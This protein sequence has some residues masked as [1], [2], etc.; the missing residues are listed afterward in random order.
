MQIQQQ[1]SKRR[2]AEQAEELRRWARCAAGAIQEQIRRQ[3]QSSRRN[4]AS[5]Q[6][7]AVA[8]TSSRRAAAVNAVSLAQAA[9]AAEGE[10][11]PQRRGSSK[12]DPHEAASIT[13]QVVTWNVRCK[14]DCEAVTQGLGGEP[15]DIVCLQEVGGGFASCLHTVIACDDPG[16]ATRTAIVVHRRRAGHVVNCVGSH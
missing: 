6:A 5:R 3:W 16:G 4:A 7:Q 2:Y 11:E 15:W 12:K 14:S 8:D 1:S 10:G 13:L 9:A